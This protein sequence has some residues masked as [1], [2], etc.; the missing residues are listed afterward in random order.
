M[1][2]ELPSRQ[3]ALA[4]SEL[5]ER[6]ERLA[7][8]DGPHATAIPELRLSRHSA[9]SNPRPT[10]Q[11]SALCLLI[12]GR[13]RMMIAEGWHTY[14]PSHYFLMTVDLPIIIQVLEATPER[15]CLGLRIRI[16]P[17]QVSALIA[18][19]N[20][21]SIVDARKST[22]GVCSG[23][24]DAPLLEA[25]VRLVRLLDRPQH[26]GVLA[27]MAMRE[28]LYLLL[29]GPMGENMLRIA[30]KRGETP[31]IIEAFRWLR[32]NFR[33]SVHVDD[34]AE[35]V[36]MSPSVFYRR[37][38]AVA[39]MTPVQYLKR[40]RLQEARRLM[41]V[42]GLDAASSAYRVGYESASQF[43]R[44]YHRLFGDAPRRDVSRL[45]SDA[46]VD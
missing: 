32:L 6:V 1:V 14:D 19:L 33:Q 2:E 20:L 9:P 23:R 30:A 7:A 16:D 13:K 35:Q 44:E 12:Q 5:A 45:R 43:N 37:F 34:L 15:P 25:I 11:E 28:I 38:K 4:M 10:M 42:E 31:D 8:T 17:L 27:P 3:L 29:V 41:L 26:L 21:P 22:R 18:E 24:T 36:N 39:S 46:L 40:M